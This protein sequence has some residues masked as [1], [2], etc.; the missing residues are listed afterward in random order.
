MTRITDLSLLAGWLPVV[1]TVL[2]AVGAAWLLIAHTRRYVTTI[3]PIMVLTAAVLIMALYLFV[4]EV[5]RPFSD[6]IAVSVYVLI[7]IAVAAVLLVV[8]RILV[9]RT[10]GAGLV[11]VLAAIVVLVAVGVRINRAAADTGGWT[12]FRAEGVWVGEQLPSPVV[13]HAPTP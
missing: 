8:P 11:T 10:V 6:P 2:G 5:W 12:Q 9:R 1:S 3:M 7:G 13:R 4:E